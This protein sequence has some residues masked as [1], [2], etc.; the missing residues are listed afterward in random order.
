MTHLGVLLSNNLVPVAI[1]TTGAVTFYSFIYKRPELIIEAKP[2]FAFQRLK[3]DDG[4]V[5]AG[6][7][8]LLANVGN[9]S[10]EEVH[11]SLTSD[12]FYFDNEIEVNDTV[13]SSYEPPQ[14]GME[15]RA[16]RK[17][18]FVG[19]G[20][21]HD[22]YL[23]NVVYEGDVQELWL[24]V[25][26]FTEGRHDLKY[27]VACKEHGPRNGKISFDVTVDGDGDV[28]VEI[29]ERDY[30]TRRRQLKTRWFG[31]VER[32]RT[33]RLENLDDDVEFESDVH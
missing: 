16:G 10:A 18:V 7:M 20:S 24:G 27:Q 30:P 9:S 31:T 5:Q 3:D 25:S 4:D 15:I 29:I 33:Q 11:L 12:V 23:D 22:I 28:D 13:N 14:A 8:L 6:I 17:T 2:S 1:V 19:G 32:T 26:V 21:R